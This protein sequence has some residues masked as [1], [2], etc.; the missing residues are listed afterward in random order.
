[1]IVS[2]PL[3]KFKDKITIFFVVI[4]VLGSIYFYLNHLQQSYDSVQWSGERCLSELTSI[5]YQLN[6]V[7]EY[8]NRIDKL[9]TETQKAHDMEKER[10]K[11]IMDSC[12]AMKQQST[13]CQ[14]QFEDLQIECKKVRE[15]YNKAIKE[16]EKLKSAG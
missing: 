3:L 7:T 13:I 8:K 10:F 14:S 2:M 11:D 16:L 5:K 6:V 12:V 4:L 9:L 1:M 15:D